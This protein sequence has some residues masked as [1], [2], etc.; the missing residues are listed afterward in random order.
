MRKRATLMD[1]ASASGVSRQ[2]VSNVLN[3][4]ERV[5]A[6]TLDR[7]RRE[8]ERLGFRPHTAARALR[9]RRAAAL[10]IAV[11][12]PADRRLGNVLD[13]F[14]YELTVA[15]RERDVHVVTFSA[16]SAGDPMDQY[17][18]LLGVQAV[19]GFLITDTRRDDPRPAW[20][21]SRGVPFASFG[22][23][24]DEPGSTSWVDVDG[25]AGVAAGVRH[26]VAQGYRSVGFLGWPAGSPVG[27]DRRAGWLAAAVELG[28]HR[29]GCDASA[30]QDVNA[31]AEAAAPLIARLGSGGA[32]ICASDLLALG[33]WTVLRESGLRAGV[34]VGLVGFDDSDIAR[35]FDLTSVRQPLARIAATMLEMITG[36]PADDEQPIAAGSRRHPFTESGGVLLEPVVVER[37]SS[38]TAPAPS[39]RPAP[40]SPPHLTNGGTT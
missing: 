38:R 2:T 34:D 31:A 39:H 10:G 15:A 22:R 20:L 17:E 24:W 32:L 3:A 1:V 35:S 27:D 26:R 8:I 40:A 28:V 4:P 19:D 37:G 12:S 36:A 18:H 9:R 7:V 5:A 33:A 16:A 29:A 11:G 6:P 25:S 21:R 14:L 13:P 23:M 30:P